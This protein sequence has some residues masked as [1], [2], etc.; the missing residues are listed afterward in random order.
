M[1]KFALEKCLPL[2]GLDLAVVA[3]VARMAYAVTFVTQIRL[4]TEITLS[5]GE[6]GHKPKLMRTADG[7]PVSVYGDSLGAAQNIYDPKANAMGPARDIYAAWCKPTLDSDTTAPAEQRLSCNKPEEWKKATAASGAGGNVSNSALQ[8]SVGTA[9]QED[10][11][12]AN[13]TPFYGDAEKPNLKQGG[14]VIVLTW[15][16]AYRPDSDLRTDGVQAS[17]QRSIRYIERDRRVIPFHCAWTAYLANS[18]NARG[19]PAQL[20]NGERDA[21]Q[22]CSGGKRIN[23]REPRLFGTPASNT[24]AGFCGN[25]D[26]ATATDPAFCQNRSVDY[27][28]WGMQENV[29]PFHS[30]G[31]PDLGVYG[32]VTR[33]CASCKKWAAC[34]TTTIR[35]SRRSHR[36]VRTAPGSTSCS[37]PRTP[38]PA[39]PT[40]TQ[41]MDRWGRCRIRSRP[42]PQPIAAVAARW[43]TDGRRSTRRHGGSPVSASWAWVCDACADRTALRRAIPGNVHQLE[44][45]RS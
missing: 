31:G 43:A 7:T 37:T 22:D 15:I 40:P 39:C 30:A 35:P 29:S 45:K 10:D 27:L 13:R 6:N 5:E 32:T 2:A 21:K 24:N 20:C 16:S 33:P 44:A 18:G 3:R 38:R 42:R 14:P 9:W 25:K 1:K 19:A 4:D 36:P 8:S 11:P 34:S 23:V 26:P 28:K 17:A 12:A 41:S